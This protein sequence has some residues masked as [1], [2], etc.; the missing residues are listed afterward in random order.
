MIR[1]PPRSTL[2][3]YTTLF[4]SP[5]PPGHEPR[6]EDERQAAEPQ[7]AFKAAVHC[8]SP[9]TPRPPIGAYSASGPRTRR[10]RSPRTRGAP[11]LPRGGR[12][13]ATPPPDPPRPARDEGGRG[14]P[15]WGNRAEP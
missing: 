2:F 1:R 12:N 14:A 10:A 5:E 4:R 13:R 7:D 9:D 11:A 3:P 8:A 6:A 15:R